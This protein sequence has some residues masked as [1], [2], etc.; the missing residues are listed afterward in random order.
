MSGILWPTQARFGDYCEHPHPDTFVPIF[1]KSF[2]P[3]KPREPISTR[4]DY[5]PNL[6]FTMSTVL[7]SQFNQDFGSMHVKSQVAGVK[8]GQRYVLSLCFTTIWTALAPHPCTVVPMLIPNYLTS[9]SQI[10]PF[11]KTG[12]PSHIESSFGPTQARISDY[13]EP[14]SL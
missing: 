12:L 11:F 8:L 2:K 4:L 9:E 3:Q 10:A 14:P 13:P 5:P 6:I 1:R 7:S